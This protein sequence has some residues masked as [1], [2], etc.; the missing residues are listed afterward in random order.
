V[1]SII[2]FLFIGGY[3]TAYMFK[4]L[5]TSAIGK[6]EMPDWP[7]VSD[8]WGD[9]VGPYLSVLF[10]TLVCFA[11]AILFLV[12]ALYNNP[13]R[14]SDGQKA[15]QDMAQNPHVQEMMT[16]YRDM[17][18]AQQG[19]T[20]DSVEEH[21]A[22]KKYMEQLQGTSQPRAEQPGR[23]AGKFLVFFILFF[24]FLGLG[25][26][27]YP[28]ALLA[29]GLETYLYLNPLAIFT[30]IFKV[31]LPYLVACL[32]ML[33]VGF[34]NV[35]GNILQRLVVAAI[36]SGSFFVSLGLVLAQG[37]VYFYLVAVFMRILGLIYH[38]NQE[39]LNW[40]GEV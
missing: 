20:G 12:L 37:A 33:F 39:K 11:P 5:N 6:D 28:M 31:L 4:I 36:F 9:I 26:F 34:V 2:L 15:R 21:P 29:T 1:V 40:F 32:F 35:A 24:V 22:L 30:S 14:L 23:S 38:T 27:Y 16:A 3:F 19:T 18:Q 8:F 17:L 25:A 7:D 10:T 13:S